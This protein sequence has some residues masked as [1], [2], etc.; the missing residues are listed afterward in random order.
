MGAYVQGPWKPKRG[1]KRDET[2]LP[3]RPL[4]VGEYDSNVVEFPGRVALHC[5]KILRKNP[6]ITNQG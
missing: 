5:K 6:W 2:A 1:K 4:R 3:L